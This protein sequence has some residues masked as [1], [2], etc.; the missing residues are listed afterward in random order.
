[1]RGLLPETRSRVGVAMRLWSL[2][3][4]SPLSPPTSKRC[5]KSF[6]RWGMVLYTITPINGDTT[7]MGGTNMGVFA[8]VGRA[9]FVWLFLLGQ[10]AF[11][12]TF[13]YVSNAEDGDVGSN[14][15]DAVGGEP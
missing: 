12:G 9:A 11:A 8:S 6:V 7:A 14:A 5:K 10:P 3:K 1:M 4:A 2:K 15:C 13:I